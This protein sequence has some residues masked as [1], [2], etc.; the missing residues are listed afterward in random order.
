VR[1]KDKL[2]A[3]TENHMAMLATNPARVAS[4]FQDPRVKYA[5]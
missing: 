1:T 5:A 2:K 3:A 4:Y